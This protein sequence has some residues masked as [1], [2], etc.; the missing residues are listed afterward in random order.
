MQLNSNYEMKTVI[1]EDRNGLPG[2]V[3]DDFTKFKDKYPHS[4]YRFGFC[5]VGVADGEIPDGCNDWND[6]PEEALMDY[7]ENCQ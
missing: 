2:D 7:F 4:G 6:S 5:I 3:F 1:I